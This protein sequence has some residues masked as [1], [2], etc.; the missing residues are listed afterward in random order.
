MNHW[1]EVQPLLYAIASQKLAFKG[2]IDLLA[3]RSSRASRDDLCA[4]QL[5]LM[6]I[7]QRTLTSTSSIDP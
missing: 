1:F 3:D 5:Q 7:Y 4:E 2:G 6:G